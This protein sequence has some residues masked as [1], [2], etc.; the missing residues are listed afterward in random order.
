MTP[1]QT[2][3]AMDRLEAISRIGA[4]GR[5]LGLKPAVVLRINKSLLRLSTDSLLEVA[6]RWGRLEHCVQ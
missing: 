6:R 4:A 2:L 1:D 5:Q 3:D